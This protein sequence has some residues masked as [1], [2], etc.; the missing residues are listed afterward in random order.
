MPPKRKAVS[1]DDDE[2]FQ[3]PSDD[4][5]EEVI[6]RSTRNRRPTVK[7]AKLNLDSQRAAIDKQ[8]RELKEQMK[9]VKKVAKA[10]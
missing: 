2:A 10:L 9:A 1:K 3:E 8:F 7:Q 5:S 4:G 6:Q